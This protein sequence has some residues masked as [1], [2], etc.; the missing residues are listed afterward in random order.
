MPLYESGKTEVKW[1]IRETEFVIR[2]ITNASINGSDLEQ[3]LSVLNKF[4]ATH[5]NL[6]QHEVAR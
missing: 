2:L 6:V 4:K 1:D 5:N 3:A